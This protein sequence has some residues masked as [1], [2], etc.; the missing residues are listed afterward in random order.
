M[1]E[2]TVKKSKSNL[3]VLRVLYDGGLLSFVLWYDFTAMKV[4]EDLAKNM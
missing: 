1:T 2:R 3:I 4:M